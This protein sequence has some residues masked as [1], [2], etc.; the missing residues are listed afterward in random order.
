[1]FDLAVR[2]RLDPMLERIASG[3][4]R[5]RVT[6]DAVTV[7]AFLVGLAAAAAIAAQH[8]WLGLALLLLSRLGDGLDGAV[9]RASAQRDGRYGTDFGGYL[10]IVL[11]FGFY[12][13]VPLGFVLADPAAN[14]VPGAVLVAAFYFNGASF[15]AFAT[16]A[17]KRGGEAAESGSKAFRYTVGLM[18]GTETIVLFSA[19]CVFPLWFPVIAYVFAALTLATTL[20]RIALARQTFR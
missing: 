8:F 15:L 11:D 3:L 14:A 2:R 17:A 9:A 20:A 13:A 6:A 19:M 16:A 4:V 7:A 5:H 12:A 1:M 18:E 10:D